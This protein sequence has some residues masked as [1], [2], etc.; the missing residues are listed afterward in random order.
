M[1]LTIEQK[2]LV[3]GHMNLVPYI[4]KKYIICNK[5]ADMG[6]EEL[7]QEGNLALCKAAAHYNKTSKFNTFAE[8]IVRNELINY[9]KKVSKRVRTV[10]I[11][12]S[13][14]IGELVT[15][16]N[17]YSEKLIGE[18]CIKVIHKTKKKYS[19]VILKGLNAIEL[20]MKG[21]TGADIAAMYG[22]KPNLV[23]AWISKAKKE[24]LNDED[25]LKEISCNL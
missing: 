12:E 10:N 8:I 7:I 14:N 25:F 3:E 17:D 2:M 11:D 5:D 21:L 9:C 16:D 13:I 23:S 6:Y 4:I 1:G 20:R 22:V 15:A 18:E 19:G 24:L